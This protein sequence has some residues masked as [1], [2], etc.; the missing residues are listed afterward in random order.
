MGIMAA[1]AI[2]NGCFNL[3]MRLP[4]GSRLRV[5]AFTAQGLD[6]LSEQINLCR[7]MGLMT[8]QAIPASRLMHLFF[9]HFYFEFIMAIQTNVRAGS[10]EKA[11]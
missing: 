8:S 5:M 10:Q 9:P 6:L 3:K 1:F 2:H 4:K 7:I 11:F